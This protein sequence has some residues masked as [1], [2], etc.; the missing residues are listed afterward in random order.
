MTDNTLSAALDLAAHYPVFPVR[1]C[2]DACLKCDVCKTPAC[3]HGF[4]DASRD[5][6]RVRELWSKYPGQLIG[7]PTGETSGFD[8][9]DI[10]SKKHPEA[11]IWWF[12]HRNYIPHTRTHQTG[13]GGLHLLFKHHPQARTGNGRLGTGIDV[14]AAGGY[15]I[16]WPSYGRKISVDKPII[17][18]PNWLIARQQPIQSPSIRYRADLISKNSDLDGLARFVASLPEGNRNNGAFWAFCRAYEAVAEG[19]VSEHAAVNQIG[20]AASTSGLPEKEIRAIARS[21]RR[22]RRKS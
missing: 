17:D 21:A 1:L 10:D 15:I 18:W 11:I 16:W 6:D 9:L 12:G 5:P 4:K 13:S 20:T 22:A 3:S 14:K 8:V 19:L 2:P 7:V